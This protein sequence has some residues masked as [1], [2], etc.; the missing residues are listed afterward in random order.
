[1]FES[2]IDKALL[3]GKFADKMKFTLMWENQ[4]RG[5]AGVTDEKDLMTNLM[6]YWMEKYFKNPSYL[7][8]DNKPVLFIY[9]PEFLI[10]DLGGE[11]NVVKAFDKMRQACRDAGFD[12]L[13]LLGE[14]RGLDPN[15]LAL[16]KRI[17]L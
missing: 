5:K 3:K 2:A 12:G 1:M 7:K 6:P 15:Q 13:H 11:A 16:M 10:D 14:Y 8:V 4:V 17:G 9:R